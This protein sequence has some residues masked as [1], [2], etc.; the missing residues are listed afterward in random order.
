M[1]KKY[2]WKKEYTLVLVANLVYIVLF[3]IITNIYTK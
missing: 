3:Y 2:V 1:D